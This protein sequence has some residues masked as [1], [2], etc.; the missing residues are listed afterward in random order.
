MPAISSKPARVIRWT[1]I[2]LALVTAMQASGANGQGSAK[3]P[4]EIAAKGK[5]QIT[6][7]QITH[8]CFSKFDMVKNGYV[9]STK[10]EEDRNVRYFLTAKGQKLNVAALSVKKEK[11]AKVKKEKVAKP[12]K[13]KK[14]K[15][16]PAAAAA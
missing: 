9:S 6:P 2:K 13:E 4:E 1:P 14:A 16:E 11:P 5:G 8:Q 12:K 10:F 7:S 3:T 15:A